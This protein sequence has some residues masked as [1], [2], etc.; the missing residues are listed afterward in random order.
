MVASDHFT[1]L[2]EGHGVDQSTFW[3]SQRPSGMC[4][5]EPVLSQTLFPHTGVQN[6]QKENESTA[7][8]VSA[9][10]IPDPALPSADPADGVR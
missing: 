10:P 6:V 5:L 7:T 8:T 3:N 4:L 9:R 2:I 1:L